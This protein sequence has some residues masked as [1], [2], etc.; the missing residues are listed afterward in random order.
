MTPRS[1]LRSAACGVLAVA[2]LTLPGIAR[3]GTPCD[4]DIKKLCAD[5]PVGSGR[6]QECLKQHKKELSSECGGWYENLEKTTGG[7]TASCR[8]D[9]ARF[10]KGV[11]PGQ[12]RVADCLEKHRSEL[13]ATCGEELHKAPKPR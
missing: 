3:A 6:V 9:I 4:A 12:G 1:N 13:N 11:S 8:N 7:I 10:C 2:F 5:V